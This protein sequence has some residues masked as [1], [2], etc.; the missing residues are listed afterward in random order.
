VQRSSEVT[1]SAHQ[2]RGNQQPKGNQQ[3]RSNRRPSD[4][5]RRGR[6]ITA[7]PAGTLPRWV[8]DEITHSTPRDRRE[9]AFRHLE[10]AIGQFADERYR[11]AIDNLDRAK[12]LAPR[13][14]TVRELL[15]LASYY[16][17]RWEPAL[18]ELRAFRRLS[19]ETIHMPVEMDCQRALKRWSGVEK[20][21]ELFGELGGDHDTEL[22]AAV[23]YASYLLDRGRV[24]EAWK[25][26]KPGRL[27]SPAPESELRRWFVAARVALAAG[28][29]QAASKFVNAIAKQDPHLPGLEELQARL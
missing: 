4:G 2:P 18:Q 7:V 29:R 13:A 5:R 28:D 15:G 9:A 11:P 27:V 16:S 25:V 17:E 20:T 24:A 23:V 3:P 21:W 10:E 8:R 1:V 26:I 22:E 19:G 14:A 12:A 6:T